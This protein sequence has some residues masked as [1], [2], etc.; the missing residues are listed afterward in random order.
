MPRLKHVQK[1][2]HTPTHLLALQRSLATMAHASSEDSTVPMYSKKAAAYT[3][4]LPAP[5]KQVG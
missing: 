3:Q 1:E 2:A 4:D 5:W